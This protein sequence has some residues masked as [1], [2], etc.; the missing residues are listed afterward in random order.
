MKAR[1]GSGQCR[2][3]KASLFSV[4]TP[5]R[6]RVVDALRIHADPVLDLPDGSQAGFV[7]V[8]THRHKTRARGSKRLL[9]IVVLSSSVRVVKRVPHERRA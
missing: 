2:R 1:D 8:S 3:S 4:S 7:E 6:L 9:P 5:V